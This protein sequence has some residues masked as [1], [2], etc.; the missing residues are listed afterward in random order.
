MIGQ[1][2]QLVLV[3]CAVALGAPAASA[4]VA[5]FTDRA[6]F[7]TETAAAETRPIPND[8]AGVPSTSW[9]WFDYAAIEE[10]RLVHLGLLA[11]EDWTVL[12]PGNT[13]AVSG[14]ERLRVSSARAMTALGFDFAEHTDNTYG[15]FACTV[16]CPCSN[17][18]FDVRV[19]SGDALLGSIVFDPPGNVLAFVGVASDVPFD[20]VEFYELA[21]NCDDEYWGVPLVRFA[22]P[23]DLTLDG[24]VDLQDL[25]AVLAHFGTSAVE[26]DVNADGIVNV[27]DLNVVLSEFGTAC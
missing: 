3:G 15:D 12:I 24:V 10:G 19:F 1:R 4:Q 13:I 23:A 18:Q 6:A 26:G 22:C 20:R 27:E 17:S 14:T 11:D 2:R 8:G 9:S 7:V 21:A 16:H 5:L 25:N